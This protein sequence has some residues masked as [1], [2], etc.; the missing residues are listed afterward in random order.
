MEYTKEETDTWGHVFRKLTKIYPTHACQEHNDAF[1][2]MVENCG[3]REDNIPQ[4]QDIS[5]YLRGLYS[6]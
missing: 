2:L 4:L 5:G 3:Y 1:P 6:L